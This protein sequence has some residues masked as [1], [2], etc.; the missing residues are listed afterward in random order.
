VTHRLGCWSLRG[1][2]RERFV[3][4][5]STLRH[6]SEEPADASRGWSRFEAL[7]LL[8]IL[9]ALV[10]L[11]VWAVVGLTDRDRMPRLTFPA[12]HGVSA[13]DPEWLRCAAE[14]VENHPEQFGAQ[15][16]FVVE[17][18]QNR[19]LVRGTG[20]ET[21]ISVGDG[22]LIYRRPGWRH[23]RSFPVNCPGVWPWA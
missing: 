11:A 19:W 2:L 20:A 5:V 14:T 22:K 18:R 17:Y 4:G 10:A 6:V 7:V 13:S 12:D 1:P 23:P 15:H 16:G 3:G 21:W 9:V 8:G